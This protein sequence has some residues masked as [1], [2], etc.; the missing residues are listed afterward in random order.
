MTRPMSPSTISATARPRVGA[1]AASFPAADGA[2]GVYPR[3]R[4]ARMVEGRGSGGVRRRLGADVRPGRD[5]DGEGPPA[6]LAPARTNRVL[7]RRREAAGAAA[8]AGVVALHRVPA[9]LRPA[10]RR[11]GLGLR[12]ARLPAAARRRVALRRQRADRV[13]PGAD[14]ARRA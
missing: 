6:L 11:R 14:L 12:R 13:A 8:R 7:A 2:N 4:A 10:A 5:P 1:M 3:A 9:R